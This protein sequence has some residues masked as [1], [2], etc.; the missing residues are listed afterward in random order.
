MPSFTLTRLV[1]WDNQ[2]NTLTE[3]NLNT[4]ITLSKDDANDVTRGY[5]VARLKGSVHNWASIPTN[6]WGLYLK[7]NQMYGLIYNSSKIIPRKI[8]VSVSH[9]IP[10][11]KY[12]GTSTTS[13][14]SFNNTIYSFLYEL[15]DLD[16][17]TTDNFFKDADHFSVFTSSMDGALSSDNTR[18]NLPKP[19]ILFKFPW[20]P[21]VYTSPTVE[22]PIGKQT[23]DSSASGASIK[24]LNETEIMEQFIP[25]FFYDTDNMYM[26]YPGENQ[27]DYSFNVEPTDG[28]ALDCDTVP[29]NYPQNLKDVRTQY[30]LN[31]NN[32][33]EE[34]DILY[35]EIVPRIRYNAFNT[36]SGTNSL[37]EKSY[38]EMYSNQG[39]GGFNARGPPKLFIKG[40][41]ILDDNNSVVVH[42]FQGL[43]TWT[44]EL[45]I[46]PRAPI[47]YRPLT[48]G[49]VNQFN[50]NLTSLN[51]ANEPV[52]VFRQNWPQLS[53]YPQFLNTPLNKLKFV[54][55]EKGTWSKEVSCSRS[56]FEHT[57][58]EFMLGRNKSN[59]SIQ[60][61]NTFT[62]VSP[63]STL[64]YTSTEPLVSSYRK[65]DMHT[66]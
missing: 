4:S 60:P 14:L 25:E 20:A 58:E 35:N 13:Q 55:N 37:S 3:N 2:L 66:D 64:A 29:F 33:Y 9:T 46:E 23:K 7:E 18:N 59:S 51:D 50:L 39:H 38:A 27:Y 65:E 34:D 53:N 26:L 1:Y 61:C 57:P 62:K 49:F 6:H 12:A 5:R 22:Q 47:V 31:S 44:I 11:A 54:S 8:N 43:V 16:N 41:P 10:I 63:P 48:N 32:Q 30:H 56:A 24:N 21:N 28:V 45:D 52:T 19:D 17:V 40:N 36:S 42:Q 15:H